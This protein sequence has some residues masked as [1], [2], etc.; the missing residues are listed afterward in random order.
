MNQERFNQ[1]LRE[2]NQ[3]SFGEVKSFMEG[4]NSDVSPFIQN[5][6]VQLNLI[7]REELNDFV[8]LASHE[9][10]APL[11]G[12]KTL[13]QFLE[14]DLRDLEDKE[15]KENLSLLASRVEKSEQIVNDILRLSRVGKNLETIQSTKVSE[16]ILNHQHSELIEYSG[17]DEIQFYTQ[18]FYEV[19][20]ELI[21]NS[22][23]H[24]S[25]DI[26]IEIQ[27]QEKEDAYYLSFSDNGIGV[28]ETFQNKIWKPFTFL[29]PYD[30]T[31]KTGIGMSIVRK[32]VQATGGVI[33]VEHCAKPF[34]I[35][36]KIN[37]VKS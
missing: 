22:V 18:E 2:L 8:Y 28:S 3:L 30:E 16:W 5:I 20:N 37:K 35:L 26:K 27:I 9:L 6:V 24:N 11:R 36:W 13:V 10:N 31:R 14:E 32:I 29:K 1:V 15:V 34:T 25:Q 19:L 21:E 7:S 23:F 33:E 17:P 12:I 4:T